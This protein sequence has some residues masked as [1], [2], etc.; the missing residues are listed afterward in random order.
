MKV[1]KNW[2]FLGGC[3]FFPPPD[4]ARSLTVIAV[5]GM[6]ATIYC[7]LRSNFIVE[8]YRSIMKTWRLKFHFFMFERVN[9]R[10]SNSTGRYIQYT[11]PTD[12][13]LSSLVR[14]VITLENWGWRIPS[15][16]PGALSG[17]LP[18]IQLPRHGGD[19]RW[20][21]PVPRASSIWYLKHYFN[22]HWEWSSIRNP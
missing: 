12:W 20:P 21:Y 11:K 3:G 4:D 5:A 19:A 17:G 15:I 6:N 18:F 8:E 1:N 16:F 2:L 13:D 7:R 10:P 14:I 22:S 9:W